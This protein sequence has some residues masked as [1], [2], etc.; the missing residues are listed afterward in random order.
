VQNSGYHSSSLCDF[1]DL[2]LNYY[3]KT[4]GEIMFCVVGERINTSREK[5]QEAVA[6]RDAAYIQEDVKK[7]QG[8]G[9]DFIDVNAGARIGHEMED[10]KWL[11]DV[12]QETVTMPL[13]LDSPDPKVLE[14]AYHMV[15]EKPMINSISLEKE[16]YA[17]MAPFLKGKECKVIALCVDDSGMPESAR[18]TVDRA[19]KLVRKLEDLGVKRDAIFVDPLVQ[20]VGTDTLKSVMVVEAVRAIRKKLPG[21]RITGGLSN[22]SFGLPQRK[23]INRTFV[24]LMM[25]AGMDSAIIDPLDQAMMAT[26]KTTQMLIGKDDFCTEYLK[27]VRAGEIQT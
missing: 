18:D 25:G 6:E 23:I 2:W 24:C 3:E 1:L 4:K 10:M 8:A 15:K 21:V 26:I 11:L 19:E 27:A 14:M 5:V 20:P 7:Q 16:R 22:I 9:A 12:I 17:A 13:C